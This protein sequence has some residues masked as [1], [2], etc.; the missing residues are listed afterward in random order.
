M[1]NNS[2]KR[3][4]YRPRE[5]ADAGYGTR[6]GIFN[7][8]KNKKL[9]AHKVGRATI[10]FDDELRRWLSTFPVVGRTPDATA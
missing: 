6:T 9:T 4:A 1:S 2:I 7:A 5:A 3:I 8:I 10:I